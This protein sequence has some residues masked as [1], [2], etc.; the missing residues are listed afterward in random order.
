MRLPRSSGVLLHPTSLPGEFGIGDLGKES[1]DFLAFL[2][3]TGQHWWQIL[4]VGPTGHGNSPY[5]S[6]SSFAGNPLLI[7]PMGLIERRWIKPKDFP[8]DPGFRADAVEFDLVRDFKEALLRK[9]FG[10]FEPDDVA[11]EEFLHANEWWLEDYT[12]FM[13]LK[14]EHGGSAWYDW[15]PPLVRRSASAL[16]KARARLAEEIDYHRFVQYAFELQWKEFR[17]ACDASDIELIGDL[18]IFVA[19]DSADVWS[20]PDLFYL[21][22]KG[23]AS[24]VAGVPPDYFSETGQLWGNPLY[25]WEAHKLESYRWWVDRLR[26]LLRR[27]RLVRIDHFRGFESYWEVPADSDS[28][29]SGRWMP[30]PG[31]PFF[32]EVGRQLGGLPLIAEDLGLITSHVEELR[33]QFHLPGMRVLQFAFGPDPGSE[34]Y[35]PHRYVP[36][37]VAYTGTHD[38]DTMVGWYTSTHIETTQSVYEVRAERDFARRYVGTNAKQINWDM[39][40]L[41]SASVADTAIFPLQDVLGLGSEARM[42]VPG[43]ADGNWCWRFRKSKLDAKARDLLAEVTAV[44]SRW[45]GPVPEKIDPR[46]RPAREMAPIPKVETLAT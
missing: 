30:G 6:H 43:R 32:H 1:R 45:N 20:R 42:N 19:L 28:A 7:S 11:Y 16:K 24:V 34:K 41:A 17:A 46:H 15:D 10:A 26:E 2:S 37:C 36:N 44:Y 27:V 39:I 4:P 14:K 38:N 29:A 3:Q 23:R 40:R 18:P 13:A 5:Q 25:R 8:P 21:D 22:K 33:D 31:A 9:S 12:L 35:L